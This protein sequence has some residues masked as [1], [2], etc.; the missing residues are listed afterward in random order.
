MKA[1]WSCPRIVQVI[2]MILLVFFASDVGRAVTLDPNEVPLV[3]IQFTLGGDGG[4]VTTTVRYVLLRS[5]IGYSIREEA[6]NYKGAGIGSRRDMERFWVEDREIEEIVKLARAAAVP[7]PK[8]GRY[9]VIFRGSAFG[10]EITSDWRAG[11]KERDLR[12][13]LTRL[14]GIREDLREHM[15]KVLAE[16]EGGKK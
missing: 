4:G 9:P 11:L 15:N 14:G 5:G 6:S 3:E 2:W 8:E 7:A 13:L 16:S 10:G 12:M 1:R